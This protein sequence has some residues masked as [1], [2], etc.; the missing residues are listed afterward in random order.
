MI[1]AGLPQSSVASLLAALALGTKD[2]FATVQGLTPDI[3]SV[4]QHAYKEGSRQAY[5]TVFFVSI[6]F[7]GLA[8]IMSF[9]APNVDN[10]MTDQIATILNQDKKVDDME[11]HSVKEGAVELEERE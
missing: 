9:W 2:A 11:K 3:L 6:A 7:S 8:V 1:A 4:G 10:L 5:Q